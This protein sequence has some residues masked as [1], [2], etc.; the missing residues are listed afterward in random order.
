MVTLLPSKSCASLATSLCHFLITAWLVLSPTSLIM[1]STAMESIAGNNFPTKQG[2]PNFSA[3]TSRLTINN[4]VTTKNT[5]FSALVQLDGRP[6][7]MKC[8]SEE[9][10]AVFSAE[11]NVLQRMNVIRNNPTLP[12]SSIINGHVVELLDA[13]SPSLIGMPQ[14]K[15]HC[16]VTRLVERSYPLGDVIKQADNSEKDAVA[17][18][19]FRQIILTLDAIHK[20]GWAHG[21]LK[22]DNIQVTFAS[23]TPQPITPDNTYQGLPVLNYHNQ[24]A[25]L[26]VTI[27]DLVKP[28]R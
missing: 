26:R 6:G 12:Y 2:A 10:K 24:P 28:H 19:L 7:Y 18:E 21:D 16:I 14:Q 20:T 27:I 5:L 23:P 22:M 15:C 25:V 3:L 8:L 1:P 17:R 4:V 13:F 9:D 11:V